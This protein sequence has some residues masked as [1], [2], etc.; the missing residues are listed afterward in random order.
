MR[1]AVR[2]RAPWCFLKP[3]GYMARKHTLP[4]S[5]LGQD[6]EALMK[7]SNFVNVSVSDAL[8]LQAGKCLLRV[9]YQ[10][11]GSR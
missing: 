5:G 11:V 6:T 8:R 4:R 10:C 9:G 7:P 2:L 1:E 3:T